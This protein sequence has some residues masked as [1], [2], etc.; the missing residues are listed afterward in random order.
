MRTNLLFALFLALLLGASTSAQDAKSEARPARNDAEL[1]TWLQRMVWHHGYSMEEMQSVLGLPKD[2][3][4]AALA[5]FD[6]RPETKPKR[7]SDGPLLLM[8][9]PGGR[10]PRIG[11]LDGAVNPQRETKLSIFTP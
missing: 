2:E 7:A 5:K 3:I 10:H 9:Y 11:F 1:R 8:P 6:I 4:T